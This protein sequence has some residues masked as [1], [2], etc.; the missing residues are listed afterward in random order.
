M[1]YQYDDDIMCLSQ[2]EQYA[3]EAMI[4]AHTLDDADFI[5]YF[6]LGMED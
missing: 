3:I 6:S 5:D 1:L 2:D 4:D